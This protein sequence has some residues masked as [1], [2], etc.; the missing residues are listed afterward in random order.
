MYLKSS[1]AAACVGGLLSFG[2]LVATTGVSEAAK[3]KIEQTAKSKE[4][5]AQADA[6]GLHGK[7]RKSFRAKCKRGTAT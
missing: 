7:E 6:K 5:S 3:A 2:V 1:I 4:C